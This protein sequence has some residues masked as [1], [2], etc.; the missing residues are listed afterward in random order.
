M[1]PCIGVCLQATLEVLQM[2]PWMLTLA[3]LRVREPDSRRGIFT[4]RPVIAHI[5]PESC[6]FWSCHCQAQAPASVYRRHEAWLLR[7]HA[8]ESHRSTERVTHLL[9]LPSRPAW[10]AQSQLPGG[11][12]SPTGDRA[13][14]DLRT[15][16]PAH[17]PAAPVRQGHAG[18]DGMAQALQ[19]PA[20]NR[21][22]RTSAAR[23]E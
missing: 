15:S 13:A 2:L 8:S 7:A 4:R 22:R 16:R 9:H 1:E 10:S 11:R 12:R 19:P 14:S 3:I 18:S 23:G 17:G 6:P 21:C 20:H 5:G